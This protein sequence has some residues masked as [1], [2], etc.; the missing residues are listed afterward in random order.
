MGKGWRN[1]QTGEVN[2]KVGN[3]HGKV[4]RENRAKKKTEA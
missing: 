2:G 3:E 4:T 1:E